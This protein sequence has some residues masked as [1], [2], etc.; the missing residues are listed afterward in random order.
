M[1]TSTQN[2]NYIFG[3][4]L[5]CR[6]IFA[7]Y[8]V[9]VPHIHLLYLLWY[10]GCW[11]YTFSTLGR[12]HFFCFLLFVEPPLRVSRPKASKLSDFIPLF[13]KR[14]PIF[15]FSHLLTS[16]WFF[17]K[18]HFSISQDGGF[19]FTTSARLHGHFEVLSPRN[20]V[21]WRPR[22]KVHFRAL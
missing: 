2:S 4:V 12:C 7:L 5:C 8:C 18:I 19:G 9:L 3:L 21:M 16:L 15:S 10:G 13:K 20:L 1:K 6:K 17:Y 22:W 11:S 14:K